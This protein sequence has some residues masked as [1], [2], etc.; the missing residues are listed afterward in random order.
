MKL[1]SRDGENVTYEATFWEAPERPGDEGSRVR[2]RV[3]DRIVPRKRGG[4]VVGHRLAN[5]S[6]NV[7]YYPALERALGIKWGMV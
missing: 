2:K 3:G 6:P 1:I 5:T 7:S 4:K